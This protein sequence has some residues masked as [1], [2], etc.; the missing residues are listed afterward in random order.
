MLYDTAGME[1]YTETIPPTYFRDA[2]AVVLVYSI[3]CDDSIGNI[4]MWAGNFNI[5]RLG[6]SSLGLTPILVGNKADLEE[7]RAV[8]LNRAIE[9]GLLCDVKP[10]N[11]IEVSAKSG[12]GVQ[13]LFDK[14]ALLVSKTDTRPRRDTVIP[15]HE[16]EELKNSK[17][18]KCMFCHTS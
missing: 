1:R 3:D 7:N 14:I 9:T 4:Q 5:C 11:V 8:N 13:E 6:E 15:G 12:Q 17:T 18:D 10:E 16:E 2:K